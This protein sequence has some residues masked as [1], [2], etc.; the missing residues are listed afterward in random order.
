MFLSEVL[1]IERFMGTSILERTVNEL[2]GCSGISTLMVE[3]EFHGGIGGGS[4]N[5]EMV[6]TRGKVNG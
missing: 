1:L 6:E 5:E 3:L 2:C 4:I